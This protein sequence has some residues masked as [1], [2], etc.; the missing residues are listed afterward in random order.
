MVAVECNID[1]C[2]KEVLACTRTC[3]HFCT[4]EK[5]KFGRICVLL[6]PLTSRAFLQPDL[7]ANAFAE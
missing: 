1:P 5:A 7:Q 2:Y 6:T 4:L 3:M